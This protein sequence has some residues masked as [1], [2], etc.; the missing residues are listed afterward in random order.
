MFVM[1]SILHMER[2]TRKE[3]EALKVLWVKGKGFVK[4]LVPLF[5]DPKPH[6]NTVS[7]LIRSL[8]A[9][10]YVGHTPY[11]NTHEYYPLISKEEYARR[12]LRNAVSDFFDSSYKQMVTFFTRDEKLDVDDLK[13]IIRMIEQEKDRNDA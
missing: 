13:E 6:Y 11:G 7:T 3:E 5:P 9:K 10:G 8:E 4:D 1:K 2:L 12:F